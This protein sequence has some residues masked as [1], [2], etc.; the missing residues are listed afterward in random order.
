MTSKDRHFFAFRNRFLL[1]AVF[2]ALSAIAF[3]QTAPLQPQQQNSPAAAWETAAGGKQQFEV[4]S[5]RLSPPDTPMRTNFGLDSFEDTGQLHGI[6]SANVF[7]KGY[8]EFAYKLLEFPDQESALEDSIPQWSRET[9]IAI[10]ARASGEPTKDQMR[11]MMQ[12]LLQDR[13]KLKV[14]VD[15]RELPVYALV[16]VEPGKLGPGL[17]RRLSGTNC[18]DRSSPALGPTAT[19]EPPGFCGDASWS[20]GGK[21]HI[22]M[23]NATMKHFAEVLT[24]IGAAQGDTGGRLIVDETGLTGRFDLHLA[25]SPQKNITAETG[26]EGQTAIEAMKTQLGLKLV[27]RT[28]PVPLYV[29]EHVERPSEN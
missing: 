11:L 1:T 26:S 24:E 23:L 17:Q 20:G 6:F 28:A 18:I 22:R 7:L 5:L 27:K 4:A 29:I 21:M 15:T 9:P 19:D 14:R 3:C 2:A 12:S 16:L 13:L 25:C 10:E 8:V